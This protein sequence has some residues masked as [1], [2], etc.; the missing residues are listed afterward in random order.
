MCALT[1]VFHCLAQ[2]SAQWIT[3]CVTLQGH[4]LGH[5]TGHMSGS[6]GEATY[7]VHRNLYT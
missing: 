2:A 1:A 7:P 4:S 3:L 6:H 5:A